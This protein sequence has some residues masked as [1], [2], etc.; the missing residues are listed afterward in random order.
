MN[1]ALPIPA[2]L[3]L[4]FV[5]VA[6][7]M[8]GSAI[9]WATYNW[10]WNPRAISPWGHPPQGGPPRCWRDRLPIVGWLGLR[11]E[12]TLHGVAFW[13]R[14][15]LVELATAIGLAWLYHREVIQQGLFEFPLGTPLPLG[16]S[17]DVAILHQQFLAHVLLIGLAL[18]ASLIDIDEKLIPDEVTV[19]GTILGLI[20]ALVLPFSLLPDLAAG[21]EPS[22]VAMPF[23]LAPNLQGLLPPGSV[24]H[25]S[26]LTATS[27]NVWPAELAGSPNGKS[28][29]IGLGCVWFWCFAILPRPW[30]TRHG[31]ARAL[32]VC[33]ARMMRGFWTLRSLILLVGGSTLVLGGWLWGGAHWAGLLT[34]LIGMFGGGAIV[35]VVRIIGAMTLRRE[36]M[37]FGDVL[38]MMMIGAFMGWQACLVIFFLAP[39]AGLL[40]GVLQMLARRDQEIPYGPFLCLATLFTLLAWPSVWDRLYRLFAVGWLVPYVLVGCLLAM[41]VLL[42]LVRIVKSV[43]FRAEE[44]T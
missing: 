34:A 4:C 25:H 17:V 12:A 15:M 23:V 27:P 40:I 19:T 42:M 5:F 41:I 20:I 36:A 10:A 7:A 22:V 33:T 6:A 11:R 14:P 35:W 2:T 44:P 31:L 16:V 28:L 38:L 18:V 1:A 3:A 43:I 26:L 32:R 13:I 9:N 29:L 8:L 39:F 30:Y 24:P 21:S 37:G